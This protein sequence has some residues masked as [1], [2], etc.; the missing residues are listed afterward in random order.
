VPERIP[1][2]RQEFRDFLR[3]AVQ[4]LV[5]VRDSAQNLSVRPSISPNHHP[6]TFLTATNTSSGD[7]STVKDAV[8]FFAVMTR[9]LMRSAV[10]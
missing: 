10:R 3:A 5:A 4:A 9:S 7:W 1:Y 8:Q 2:Y 6:L